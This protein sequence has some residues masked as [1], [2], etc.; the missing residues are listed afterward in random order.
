MKY[1]NHTILCLE[2]DELFKKEDGSGN[3]II[4]YSTY[5]N[6]RVRNTVKFHGVGGNGRQVLI[7]FESLPDLYKNLVIGIYGDPYQYAALEPLRLL[8]KPDVEA[9]EFFDRYELANGKPLKDELKREYVKQS[10]IMNMIDYAYA[11]KKWLKKEVKIGLSQLFEVVVKMKEAKDCGLDISSRKLFDKYNRWKESKY[12]GLV[13]GKVGNQNR[14]KVTP[15]LE[16]LILSLYVQDNKPYAQDVLDDFNQF[17]RGEKEIVDIESGEL[18]YAAMFTDKNGEL[19]ELSKTTVWSIINEPANK[20]IVDKLRLSR[21]EFNNR[22]VPYASRIA[23]TYAF[24]KLTMDDRSI[25]FKMEDG[26]RA[27]TYIIADVASQCIVGR[28]YSRS[29][30]EG[31]GKN[32]ELFKNAMNSMFRLMVNNNWGMPAEIEVEH[33]ISNTFTGKLKDNGLFVPDLL[34]DN[35]LFPFVTF[36]NPANPQQKRAEHIIRQIKYQFEKNIDGFQGRPFARQDANRLN[37]DKKSTRY[38][39]DSVVANIEAIINEWNNQLHPD[40]NK[41]TGLT[42]W[43][44]LEQYQ[45]P[46]LVKPYLPAIAKYIGISRT[47]TIN[48]TEVKVF[49]KKFI[50]PANQLINNTTVNALQYPIRKVLLMKYT[51]IKMMIFC[52]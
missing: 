28:S 34:T 50:V 46:Q 2:F 19:I 7:E 39:F 8:I 4:P 33:H 12:D 38:T 45:N 44:V 13:S 37:T 11:N 15:T 30:D 3:G 23:P 14:A 21:L 25:P 24:S 16:R 5:R 32:R 31:S 41:Y 35:Y 42:R 47:S 29:N 36:C 17:M 49:N 27:W 51:C 18:L 40:Q 20:I 9:I 22:H 1:Y 52:V 26:S 6:W 43:Q 10:S 48:R